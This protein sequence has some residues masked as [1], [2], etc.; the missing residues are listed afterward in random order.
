MKF[1][2]FLIIIAVL[3]VVFLDHIIAIL[4][5]LGI[6]G[7]IVPLV[8]GVALVLLSVYATRNDWR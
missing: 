5:Q 7:S 6:F 4:S 8:I 3:L 2:S 1:H